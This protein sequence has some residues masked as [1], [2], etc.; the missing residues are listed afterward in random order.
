MSELKISEISVP[1]ATNEIPITKFD[2][3]SADA[4]MAECLTAISLVYIT[5]II[6]NISI[7]KADIKKIIFN[8]Y[9]I[10]F[11]LNYISRLKLF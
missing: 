1:I 7:K 5:S 9:L 6:P 4:R 3:P 11:N 2:T 10:L 8:N